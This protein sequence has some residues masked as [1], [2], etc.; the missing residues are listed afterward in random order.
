MDS[1]K[2][3]AGGNGSQ[4]LIQLIK[5]LT[6][7]YNKRR[8]LSSLFSFAFLTKQLAQE[9]ASEFARSASRYAFADGSVLHSTHVSQNPCRAVKPGPHLRDGQS[10]LPR[11]TA[12]PPLF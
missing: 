1:K 5:G 6:E 8:G 12:T 2:A 4:G 7:A 10:F 9:P 3:E 11:H